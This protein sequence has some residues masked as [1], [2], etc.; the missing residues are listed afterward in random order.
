MSR[1]PPLH[2]FVPVAR[3][4]SRI[5]VALVRWGFWEHS[6]PEGHIERRAVDAAEF[7]ARLRGAADAGDPETELELDWLG[8]W[9]VDRQEGDVLARVQSA[10]ALLLLIS[11]AAPPKT[12][13]EGL[14]TV[15]ELPLVVCGIDDDFTIRPSFGHADIAARGATVGIPMLTS[16]LMREGRRFDTLIARLDADADLADVVTACRA[17]GVAGRLRRARLARIG[18]HQE[19]YSHVDASDEILESSFGVEM[20]SLEPGEFTAAYRSAPEDEVERVFADCAPL[21]S[22]SEVNRDGL[23]RTARA[24]AALRSLVAEHHLDAGAMNCHV[25]QIRLGD[26]IGIAPCF[27]LGQ[28]TSAGSPWTC[29]GD[30]LTAMAMLIAQL[31]SRTSLYHELE[32]MDVESDQLVVANTGEHDRGLCARIEDAVMR[33]NVWF[34]DVDS[35]CGYCLQFPLPAMPA[36]LVAVCGTSDGRLRLVC[37]EGSTTGDSFDRVGTVNGGFRFASGGVREN[38]LR[39]VRAGVTHHSALTSGRRGAL[40]ARVAAH[41]D[42]EFVDVGRTE[43]EDAR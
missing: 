15:P 1:N 35:H 16:A 12:I 10:D 3:Q 42:V 7:V 36:T 21:V 25:A 37:A 30:V 24:D 28:A 27:A 20:V 18:K 14:R 43:K 6:M 2:G 13:V 9:D 23:T 22:A 38:W 5:A 17:A 41:L 33:P 40:L 4:P 32:A 8:L 34:E 29:T 26:E 11:M 39:W 31:V 19:G